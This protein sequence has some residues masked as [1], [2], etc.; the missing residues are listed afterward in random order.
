MRHILLFTCFCFPTLALAH[1]ELINDS[2]NLFMLSALL[3][4][5]SLKLGTK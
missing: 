2:I 1:H 5:L 3:L 4:F